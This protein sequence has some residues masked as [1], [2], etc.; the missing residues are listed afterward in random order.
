MIPGP[1][2]ATGPSASTQ[3][4]AQVSGAEQQVVLL[5]D[6][7]PERAVI[8]ELLAVRESDYLAPCPGDGPDTRTASRGHRDSV[9]DLS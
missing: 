6:G 4:R 5:H 1:A 8:T 7:I 9:A 2:F 3:V